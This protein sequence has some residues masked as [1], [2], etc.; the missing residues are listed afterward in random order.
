MFIDDLNMPKKEQYDAQPPIE[1]LRELIDHGY[2]YVW[3]MK[4]AYIKIEDVVILGAMGPAGGARSELTP[5]F[6]RHFNILSYP[7]MEEKVIENIFSKLVGF[8][9]KDYES[10]ITQNLDLL[11]SSQLKLFNKIR[12]FLLPIPSKSHY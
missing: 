8:F 9:L 11:I 7:E 2:W 6:V 12:A 4:K 1:L 3:K 5:R 10:D